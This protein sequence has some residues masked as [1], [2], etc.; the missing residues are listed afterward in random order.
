MVPKI[1]IGFTV[2]AMATV[3]GL[4]LQQHLRYNELESNKPGFAVYEVPQEKFLQVRINNSGNPVYK[5]QRTDQDIRCGIAG[6]A[7][8]KEIVRAANG[9]VR[10]TSRNCNEFSLANAVDSDNKPCLM[11]WLSTVRPSERENFYF[12]CESE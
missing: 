5:F 9:W 6:E 1:V 8:I 7:Q 10:D 11:P 2:A 4:A 3:A 12:V